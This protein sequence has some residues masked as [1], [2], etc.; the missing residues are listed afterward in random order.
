MALTRADAEARDAADPL[1]GFRERFVNTDPQRIYLDGNSLGRLPVTTRDRLRDL[2]EEWGDRLV[3]GWPHWIDAPARVGDALAAGVLGAGPGEVIVADSTTVNLFKLCSAALDLGAGALV[4]DSGNFPTDRYVLDGLARQRGAEL[5]IVDDVVAAL[6]G[7]AVVVLSHVDYRSGAIADV[8]G[9]TELA[10]SH[11]ARVVWDLSH[12]AGAVPVELRAAGVELAVGCTYKY[13]NAGPGAPAYLYVARE[14]QSRL[15]SPI[16]GWFGQRDQFAMERPYDPA[17]GIGRFLAGTPPIMDL[18][19]VEEGVRLTAEAGIGPLREKSVALCEL[20]VELHDAWLAPLGFELGS[21]REP[22]GAR[23]ARVLA[24]R[25]GVADLP[26]ADR[27]RGGHPRLPRAGL[28]PARRGA[29]LHPVRRHLGRARPAAR[30]GLSRRAQG[31]QRGAGPRDLAPVALLCEHELLGQRGARRGRRVGEHR[32]GLGHRAGERG[33]PVGERDHHVVGVD[34]GDLA[35]LARGETLVHEEVQQ[36]LG[37]VLEAKNGDLRALLDVGERH[38]LDALAGR[39][40]VAVRA[41]RRVADG[42]AHALLE[43]RR[44]RVLEPLRLLVH[45]VPR[46][47]QHVGQEALDQA[48]PADD[49]LRVPES[50]LREADRLVGSA[51]DVAVPLEPPDH[52]VHRRGGELHR[53][54]DVRARHR[55][56]GLLEPE[57]DLEVLL[58]GDGY[59]IL[60]HASEHILRPM[61]IDATTRALVTGASRGIGRAI[62]E[63]LAARGAAVGL[64]ARSAGELDALAASLGPRAVALPA[65]VGDRE[66]VEAAVERF[67]AEAGGLELVVANAGI[68]HYGPLLAQDVERLEAMT[69]VNWLGTVY[70]VKA[71]LGHLVDRADGHIVVV[72]SGAGLRAFP[73]AAGYGATKAA[74]RGFAEA[75]RHELS[76]SGVSVTTVFPGEIASALHD[77]EKDTMPDWYRLPP[78]RDAAAGAGR[79]AA[80][81]LRAVER[82]ERSVAYPPVVRL[83]GLNGIAPRLT[84]AILRRLRGGT[85]APRR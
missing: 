19:A 22:G 59:L 64:L 82:D 60:G 65:D 8:R 58:L 38:A 70:T 47:A 72:S 56:P 7:A 39:D 14:L 25:R 2:V 32:H 21:P 30:P 34:L 63:A 16:Q 40:R 81:V 15:R 36:V 11:G 77:H 12:S 6:P 5:R 50:L 45:V 62:A 23:L 33:V 54:G 35:L 29:A 3:S 52:L 27:T 69:R 75:L 84:D 71:T 41:G 74:Q 17:D 43:L 4:T 46:N 31:V 42:G 80:A 68:A 73:W 66:Q 20:L 26:G 76:G 44:H 51:R 85:A 28:H 61:R 78:T 48:V 83:L 55:E 37:L 67:I 1:A 18:A 24:P 49:P 10:R 13:L 9:L 79:L 57:D 53:A